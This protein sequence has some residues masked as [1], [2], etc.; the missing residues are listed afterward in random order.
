MQIINREAKLLFRI[1][2]VGKKQKI[3]P[4]K[5]NALTCCGVYNWEHVFP[6]MRKLCS[7]AG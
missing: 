7:I 4:F 6:D 1:D 5:K 2:D 3:R